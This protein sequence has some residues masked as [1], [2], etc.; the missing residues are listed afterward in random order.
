MTRTRLLAA[1]LLT[2][3]LTFSACSSEE[4]PNPSDAEPMSVTT[5]V[6][7]ESAEPTVYR[8]SGTIQG[9]RR[10]PLST[11]MMGT[12]TSLDVEAGDQVRRGQTLAR[13]RSQN[14]KAQ[15]QQVEAR[16][17]EARAALQNAETNFDRIRTLKAKDSATQKE[18]DDAK[19]GYERAKARVQAL[20][21]QLAEIND[22]L[23]YATITSPI[24]GF[25]VEK[26]SETGALATPGRPLLVVETLDDLKALVQVPEA[27]INRFQMGESVSVTVGAADQAKRSGIVTQ[28]NPAGNYASRQFEVQVRLDRENTSAIKSGMYAEIL[29]PVEAVPSLTVPEAAIVH[30]GQLT[31]LFAVR[32]STALL[33]WVRLGEKRGD[34]VEVLSGLRPGETYIADAA[35][36]ILDGQTVHTR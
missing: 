32:D 19:T 12:I 13:V 8:Y 11:K 24:D 1:L 5:A 10:I 25:V 16:L 18:F 30:R 36:R 33:R 35:G 14:L 15:K 21:G 26:R 4:A 27:E 17:Q 28:I 29:Y 20:E 31:G 34:R 2:S 23:D 9:A 22:T 7:A 6:A 3:A